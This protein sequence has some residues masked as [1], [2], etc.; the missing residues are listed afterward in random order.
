M[1]RLYFTHPTNALLFTFLLLLASYTYISGLFAHHYLLLF[2]PVVVAPFYE[3]LAHKYI[4][5]KKMPK[6]QFWQR[7]MIRL[8]YGH[9][10][11]P[12]DVKLLFAPVSAIIVLHIKIYLFYA[13]ILQSFSQALVP[14]LGTTAY[15]LYYEWVHLGHHVHEYKHLTPYGRMMKRAHMMHHYANDNYWWGITNHLGDIAF[16]TFKAIDDVEK[17]QTLKASLMTKESL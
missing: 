10:K 8:H 5:H 6:S 4:L 7:Y 3:W 1:L 17:E 12:A 16:G 15:Y 2:I 11:A 14:L 13:L 9:H